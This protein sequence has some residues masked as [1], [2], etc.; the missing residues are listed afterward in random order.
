MNAE[1]TLDQIRELVLDTQI[2]LDVVPP[3]SAEYAMIASV[4]IEGLCE[5]LGLDEREGGQYPHKNQCT[6]DPSTWTVI[7]P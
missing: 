7:K 3:E 5:L 2:Q 6:I 1:G 4:M